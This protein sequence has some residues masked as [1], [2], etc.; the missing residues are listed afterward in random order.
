MDIEI[1]LSEVEERP[2]WKINKAEIILIK[3]KAFLVA[4]LDI[5]PE[6]LS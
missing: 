3:K 4:S 5:D 6:G 1:E 2:R